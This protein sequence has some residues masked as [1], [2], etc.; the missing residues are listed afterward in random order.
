MRPLKKMYRCHTSVY[1]DTY[2]VRCDMFGTIYQ[3]SACQGVDVY[4]LQQTLLPTKRKT[5]KSK[6]ESK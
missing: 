3:C 5:A 1:P 2:Q 6:R 4:V